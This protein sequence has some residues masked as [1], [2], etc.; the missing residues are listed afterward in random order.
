MDRNVLQR[1]VDTSELVALITLALA[2]GLIAT[3]IYADRHRPSPHDVQ[4]ALLDSTW[5]ELAAGRST[6]GADDASH[7]I[8]VFTDYQCELCRAYDRVL[9]D[10]RD[11]MPKSFKVVVHQ[12]PLRAIHPTADVAAVF[13]VCATEQDAFSEAHY[14]LMAVEG[15]VSKAEAR[16]FAIQAEL[17]EPT[18]FE[19]CVETGQGQPGVDRDVLVASRLGLGRSPSVMLDGKLMGSIPG[20]EKLIA[21]AEPPIGQP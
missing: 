17:P 6:I 2:I 18:R 15:M 21:G 20:S 9:G 13:A 12:Y 8:V 14:R 19:Q 11:S 7:T 4:Q 1:L 16:T 5:A 10:L 3:T